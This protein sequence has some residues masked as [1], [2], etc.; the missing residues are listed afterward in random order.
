[1]GS[2]F[3]FTLIPGGMIQFD[4]YFLNGLNAPTSLQSLRLTLRSENRP[5]DMFNQKQ[6]T[7]AIDGVNYAPKTNMDRPPSQRHHMGGAQLSPTRVAVSGVISWIGKTKCPNIVESH[8][9]AASWKLLQVS[10][11]LR[12]AAGLEWQQRRCGHQTWVTR[13]A[14]FR[15]CRWPLPLPLA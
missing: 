11:F 6:L 12:I 9:A 13:G 15:H 5:L 1:M 8:K 10:G 14:S 2:N 4:K 7:S 3:F